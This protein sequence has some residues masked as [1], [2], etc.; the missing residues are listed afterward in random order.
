M[1]RHLTILNTLYPNFKFKK[2]S[3]DSVSKVLHFTKKYEGWNKM[4]FF[5]DTKDYSLTEHVENITPERNILFIAIK[6][7]DEENFYFYKP[8]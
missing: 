5:K 7:K 2:V 3:G 4:S 1:K 6:L 8:S